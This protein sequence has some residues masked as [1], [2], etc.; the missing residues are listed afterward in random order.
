MERAEALVTI[1]E[2]AAEVLSVDPDLVT[3]TA[4][5]KE[6]LDADSLDLVELVMGL[7]ER[8]DIEVPEDDLEGVTTIGQAVDLVLGEG[9]RV[10]NGA[11]DSERRRARSPRPGPGRR[12]RPRREDAGRDRPRHVL[13]D[14]RRRALDRGRHHALRPRPTCRCASAARSATSTRPPYLGA[15]GSAPRRPRH[16]T[17]LRGRGRRARRRRR[18]PVRPG[19][20]R[21]HRR[22]R[23]R[24]ADHARGAGRHLQR[25]GRGPGQPVPRPDD[26]GERDRGH[27]RDAVR[28]EGP[29]L[30]RRHRVRGERQR[31]RRGGAAHPRRERRH[32]DDRR[33]RVV[34]D[35]DRDLRVRAHDR[36]EHAQRRP[37]ARVAAVRR[38]PRRVR[39]GRRR[40]RARARALG[41]RRRPRRAHLRRGRRLRPQ[42]RR[43]PHHRAVAR[44]RRRGRVHA[45][46]AR[47][48]RARPRRDRPRQRAR[49]VDAAERRGRGRGDPQGVRRDAA[50]GH[51]DQGRHRSPHRRGRRDRGDR[52]P[53]R[54]RAT[55]RCRRPRTSNGSATRS[56][57]TSSPARRAPLA[58][59]PA[60]SNSFGFGG[61]NATLVLAPPS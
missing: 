31:D 14:A 35:A 3:E 5:F 15:E 37:R 11:T 46:R 42:R 57:S 34:P 24:R 21:G 44:R 59:A 43:V 60:L 22:H 25:E 39:H 29:E 18:A 41:P 61:H 40:G 33:L 27:D 51:V 48:R 23:C 52:V 55:A 9:R 20:Q 7:E 47:R 28:L 2:V 13:V 56:R 10:D 17:R 38:R 50:A 54:V 32:R 1:K 12:H 16:A 36:A 19:A 45:A 30:L 53:A 6:D 8:F 26:D 49:H 58:P 4:R